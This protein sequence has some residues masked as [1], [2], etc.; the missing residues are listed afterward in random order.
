M[1][2]AWDE[3][4]KVFEKEHPGVTVQI[5]QKAGIPAA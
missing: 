5:E 2:K 3:S 1:G 4:I